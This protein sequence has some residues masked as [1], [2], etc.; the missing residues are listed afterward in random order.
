MELSSTI[1]WR[2]PLNSGVYLLYTRADALQC[3]TAL[4][5]LPISPGA[6]AIAGPLNS[7]TGN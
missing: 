1:L 5:D 4:S 6:A 3:R 2:I 7:A